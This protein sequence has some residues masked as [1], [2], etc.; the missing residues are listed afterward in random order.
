MGIRSKPIAAGQVGQLVS[1]LSVFRVITFEPTPSYVRVFGA[2]KHGRGNTRAPLSAES[3]PDVCSAYD[4]TRL[5]TMN[6]FLHLRDAAVM[7]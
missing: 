7:K 2:T 6:Y 3:S 4:M 1:C 5:A